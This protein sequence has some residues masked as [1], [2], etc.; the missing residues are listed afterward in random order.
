MFILQLCLEER[1]NILRKCTAE[2]CDRDVI[3]KNY[4]PRHYRIFKKHGYIK[5]SWFDLSIT[6]RIESKTKINEL[7]GCL[8][9]QGYL[10]VWGYAKIKHENTMKLSHRLVWELRYGDIPKDLCILHKCDNPKC[11]NIDHLFLG[12]HAD[13]NIDMQEKGRGRY[14]RG[15]ECVHTELTEEN[16]IEIRRMLSEKIS[17]KK[18]YERF[19]IKSSAIKSIRNRHTWKH[20]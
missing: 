10:N 8:E 18:I 9:W 7:T 12:T 1:G 6:E 20:I 3:A 11:C 15:S 2:D 14:P 5:K 13:N 19:N 16:V 17:Y 4:C